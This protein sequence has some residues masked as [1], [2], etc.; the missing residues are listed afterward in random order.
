MSGTWSVVPALLLAAVFAPSAIGKLRDTRP[1]A[2]SFEALGLPAALTRSRVPA[3]LPMV[4]LLLGAALLLAPGIGYAVSA[5]LAVVLCAAYLLVVIRAAR[6]PEPASCRCFGALTSGV[7]GW[8]TVARNALLLGAAVLTFTDSR[9]GAGGDTVA[10]V[11]G[12]IASGS[13]ETWGWLGMVVLAVLV[14]VGVML[15]D[16]APH[17]E[18][19]STEWTGRAIPRLSVTG[20]DGR[21]VTLRDLALARA[22]VLVYVMPGC[23]SCRE[24][25]PAVAEFAA[26]TPEIAVHLV[27]AAPLTQPAGI[28]VL[29][30]PA[31]LVAQVFQLSAPGAVV[32][33]TD[34]LVVAGPVSGAEAVARLMRE[35]RTVM[36]SG[37]D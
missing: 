25:L 14:A 31:D 33:G 22:N 3:A 4:E 32:L 12:R 2:A 1:A 7:I 37:G 18:A 6:A 29:L 21:P 36:A 17:P 16:T 20:P 19:R 34:G 10:S 26:R 9:S 8:H 13:G 27:S 15:G 11:S 23:P 28:P 5:A 30:D 35:V 24:A